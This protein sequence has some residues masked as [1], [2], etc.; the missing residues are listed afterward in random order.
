MRRTGLPITKTIKNSFRFSLAY[1][2]SL[3][4]ALFHEA[5]HFALGFDHFATGYVFLAFFLDAG[6]LVS[7]MLLDLRQYGGLFTFL[8]ESF[9]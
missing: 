4:S 7:L 1:T 5:L 2:T 3:L 9:Q 8:L 6:L